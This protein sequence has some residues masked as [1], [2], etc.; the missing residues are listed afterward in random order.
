MQLGDLGLQVI[1]PVAIIELILMVIALV[2]LS[3]REKEET[4][5][6]KLLW[7]FIIILGNLLGSVVYFTVG[8]RSGS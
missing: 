2:D 3:R 7:V 6:P 8:R 1:L 5:G 4:R